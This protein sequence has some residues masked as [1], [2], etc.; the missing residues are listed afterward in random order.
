MQQAS[1]RCLSIAEVAEII[2]VFLYDNGRGKM[3]VARMARTSK[4]I[5][6]IA[7]AVLW[8]RI[9]GIEPIMSVIPG[10]EWRKDSRNPSRIVWQR[11]VR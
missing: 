5:H 10:Y 6:P 2:M 8:Q 11:M 1:I 4:V 3:A 9:L 7:V